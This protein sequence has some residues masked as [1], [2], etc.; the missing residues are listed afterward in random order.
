[1]TVGGMVVKKI[2]MKPPNISNP[3]LEGIQKTE[4]SIPSPTMP[5]QEDVDRRFVY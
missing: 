5:G 2:K 3:K 4:M 1:M